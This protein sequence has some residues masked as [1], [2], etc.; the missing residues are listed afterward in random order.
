[1]GAGN[2]SGVQVAGTGQLL[3]ICS[4][5]TLPAGNSQAQAAATN[6]SS[7]GVAA[8]GGSLELDTHGAPILAAAGAAAAAA[9]G[10]AE[11]LAAAASP[12][13]LPRAVLTKADEGHFQVAHT[14][15]VEGVGPVVS[16]IAVAGGNQGSET[17]SN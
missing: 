3:D 14:F 11:S 10:A 12:A 7:N 5:E 1:M 2:T 8:A 6:G 13:L 4:A 17:N 16:G 15:D 9:V